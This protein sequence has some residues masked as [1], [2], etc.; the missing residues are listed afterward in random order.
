M[1]TG[2]DAALRDNSDGMEYL[3]SYLI[4]IFFFVGKQFI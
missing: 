4:V 1:D 2:L 3:F